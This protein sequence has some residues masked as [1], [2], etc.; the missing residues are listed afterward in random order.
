MKT[1]WSMNFPWITDDF[2][3]A[4]SLFTIHYPTHECHGFHEGCQDSKGG[5]WF[6]WHLGWLVVWLVGLVG[7]AHGLAWWVGLVAW[8][9]GWLADEQ[10]NLI[11]LEL[12]VSWIWDPWMLAGFGFPCTMQQ[13]KSRQQAT[14]CSVNQTTSPGIQHAIPTDTAQACV[15]LASALLTSPQVTPVIGNHANS[16][17]G[18]YLPCQGY[19]CNEASDREHVCVG[20]EISFLFV[21]GFHIC[22]SRRTCTHICI[23]MHVYVYTCIYVYTH[24]R[25]YVFMCICTYAPT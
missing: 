17:R 25:I 24:I 21:N 23:W 13:C 19:A 16:W 9:V 14:T 8:L 4:N 11:S 10:A 22:K 12:Q 6:L 18:E 7:V 3:L 5:M 1:Q 20:V 2:F 15:D